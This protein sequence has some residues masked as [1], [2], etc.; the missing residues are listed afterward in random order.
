MNQ[1]VRLVRFAEKPCFNSYVS[2]FVVM[3]YINVGAAAN[4]FELL[5]CALHMR[6]NKRV[7]S[8]AIRFK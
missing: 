6:I 5:G 3:S 1:E 4:L 7:K 8:P 2:T